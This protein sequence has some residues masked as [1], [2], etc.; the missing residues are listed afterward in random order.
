MAAIEKILSTFGI[1]EI[2]RTGKIALVR[3]TSDMEKPIGV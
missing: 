3:E 1:S 2:A